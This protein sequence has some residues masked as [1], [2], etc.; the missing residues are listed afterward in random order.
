M[1][2][3]V[4]RVSMWVL[5]ASAL[6]GNFIVIVLRLSEKSTKSSVLVHSFLVFNLAVSD[7]QMGVYMLILASTDVYYGDEYFLY[8]DDWRASNVCKLAGFISILS[9]E[10]S[11]F[12]ITLISVDRYIAIVFPFSQRRLRIR[13]ARIAV[14]ILWCIAF[15]VGIIPVIYADPESDIYDLS[16]VCIGLPLITRPT[17]YTTLQGS[18]GNPLSGRTFSKPVAQSTKPAWY[19]SIAL[20][21][22]VNCACFLVILV[23]YVAIFIN[24]RMSMKQAK[25]NVNREEEIKMAIKM[26]VIVGTDFLCW[27]PIILTGILS[28]T[29]SVVVP[30]QM[31]TWT[32]VFILPINSSLNPYLYTISNL[33]SKRKS[34]QEERSKSLKT[35]MS[36]SRDKI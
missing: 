23:C 36:I 17:D 26:A 25:R 8:S 2:N 35:T 12:F 33:I 14:S 10:A 21:L 30:L 27:V 28:Q 6:V 18:I 19:F 13:S 1:Q 24:V 20:F 31:Y 4:L 3:Y 15:A 32:V 7:F 9:S 22:G 11:V 34:G 29:G 5:G 16:D